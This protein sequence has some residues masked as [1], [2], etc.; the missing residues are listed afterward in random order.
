[1]RSIRACGLVRVAVGVAGAGPLRA[2]G[3]VVVSMGRAL[4]RRRWLILTALLLGALLL[5]A[6]FVASAVTGRGCGACHAPAQAGERLTAGHGTVACLDCHRQAGTSGWVR[7]NV[8][9]AENLVSWALRRESVAALAA[10]P[11]EARC[12]ACHQDDLAQVV[13]SDGV[14]MRHADVAETPCARC[15]TSHPE[16]RPAAG[17][18]DSHR[19]CRVCHDG[20]EARSDC[21]TCHVVTPTGGDSPSPPGAG[22]HPTGWTLDHGMG[23]LTACADCHT[24]QACAECHGVPLPHDRAT[25]LYTHGD[26][27][28]A[29]GEAVCLS[30]HAKEACDACHTVPVPHPDGFLVE[31]SGLAVELGGEVCGTCHLRSGCDRCHLRHIHPG[32]PEDMRDQLREATGIGR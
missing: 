11:P 23:A 5:E 22:V 7:V 4:I 14:R 30:C 15:H 8:R 25:F 19:G 27:A 12:R 24:S 32:L 21:G 17:L 6:G 3:E 18:E 28:Q 20:T 29:A 10:P 2:A 31:H 1:M 9:A 13:S 26:Q 16:G